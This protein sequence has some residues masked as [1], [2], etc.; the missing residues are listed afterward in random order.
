MQVIFYD[1]ETNGLDVLTNSIMQMTMVDDGG[2]VVLNEY[3]YP[4]DGVIAA[5][6]IHALREA[7]QLLRSRTRRWWWRRAVP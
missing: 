1:L 7:R 3:V 6:H 5:S 2:G 4:F